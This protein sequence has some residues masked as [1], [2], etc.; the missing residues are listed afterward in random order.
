M[1]SSPNLVEQSLKHIMESAKSLVKLLNKN[2][3]QAEI[4]D[5]NKS[6]KKTSYNALVSSNQWTGLNSLAGTSGESDP[7]KSTCPEH[8]PSLLQWNIHSA[9]SNI[10]NL[11]LI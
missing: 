2:I 10:E 6:D 8:S 1:V 11:K 5:Q 9:K 3:I 4:H 7:T